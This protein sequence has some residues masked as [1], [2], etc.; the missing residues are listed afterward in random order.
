MATPTTTTPPHRSPSPPLPPTPPPPTSSLP[1]PRATALH[2]LYHEA[3]AHLLKTCTYPH[4]A[5]CFPTP[6]RAVPGSM[7]ALHAQFTAKLGEQLR[8][9]FDALM[10]ERG[11]VG[12]L[13]G[14]DG[15]VEGARGRRR[16][17]AGEEGGCGDDGGVVPPHTLAPKTLYLSHL[18]PTLRQYN[19]EIQQE[20]ETVQAENVVLLGRI[21]EQRKQIAGM[22]VGLDRVVA[23]LDAS[24]AALKP[25]E[26]EA[27]REEARGVDQGMGVV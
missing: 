12:A 10:A 18:A 6:A 3:T 21:Q 17:G 15:L 7:K 26:L 9:N 20:Q 2:Q 27:L 24:V 5:A 22:M 13:N 11:A 16:G 1:G 8:G 14:L 23:D 4:F 25:G 19:Q